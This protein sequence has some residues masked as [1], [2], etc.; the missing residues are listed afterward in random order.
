[1]KYSLFLTILL[2]L[3]S[4]QND[5]PDSK[6]EID[7]IVIQLA[8]EP[9]RLNPILATSALETEVFEY[10]FLSLCDIDPFSGTWV[11]V[12]TTDIPKGKISADENGDKITIY[13]I[14]IVPEA[15]WTDGS[16]VTGFDFEFTL[17]MVALPGVNAPAWKALLP[18]I[19]QVI[20]DQ[21]NPKNFKVV[22]KGDYF[23]SKEGFLSAEIY[24]RHIYDRNGV[25]FD[26]D[27]A[28]LKDGAIISQ[29]DENQTEVLT[30]LAE[31]F[32]SIEFSKGEVIEGAGPYKMVSW[33]SGQYIILERK[34]NWWGDNYPARNYLKA[35]PKRIIFQIVSD[36]AVTITQLKSGE[37][38]LA[39]LSKAPIQVLDDLRNDEDFAS[40][41]GFYYPS[42][43][44]IY[45]I[46]LNDRDRRLSDV[47]VRKA[48]A[49]SI[50]IQRM[51]DQV[52]GGYGT[53][54]ASV[55]HPSKAAHDP[56][57]Q[58]PTYDLNKSN[59][60]LDEAGWKD[61]DG[62]GI[63]DKIVNG[64]PISL[65]LRFFISGSQLSQ[66]ISNMM[67]ES[68]KEIGI[69]I[70]PVTKASSAA[71]QEN[72][73]PGDF[74]MMAQAIT[75][76]P[77]QDDLY[78]IWHSNSTGLN[79]RNWSG[80]TNSEVDKLIEVIRETSDEDERNKAY[81]S[82]QK[83]LAQDQPVLFLYAPVEKLVISKKFVPVIS[84]KS[85]GYFANAFTLSNNNQ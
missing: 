23:L 18:D 6:K 52:E 73:I 2:I 32:S 35:H 4:C 57:I 19:D 14:S 77:G 28:A 37:L 3:F 30:K 24:P 47:N 69:E 11:P 60:L 38:D 67:V 64:V 41:Y 54:V 22:I 81:L 75:S 46:L 25:L 40:R 7:Q 33:E 63:R 27:Y 1:M 51:I 72:V 58:Y 56:D 79:G 8:E 42:L 39:S 85:P 53:P 65:S 55:I 50:D 17:K 29:L 68:A 43:Y 74:E 36:P 15:I 48:L 16:P 26:Y 59:Q 83:I 66:T 10:M 20:T 78:N 9:Q 31:D 76:S 45:Y 82:V 84:S 80:Y 13:D 70:V 5:K 34:E 12:L 44:R 62:N 61:T 71:I 21:K 49:H